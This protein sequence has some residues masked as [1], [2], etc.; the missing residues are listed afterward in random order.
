[1]RRANRWETVTV[2]RKPRKPPPAK[3]GGLARLLQRVR[4]AIRPR[5]DEAPHVKFY[6]RGKVENG[7]AV[8]NS[9]PV[10][11]GAVGW[12]WVGDQ[13]FTIANRVGHIGQGEDSLPINSRRY[14]VSEYER[15][16]HDL[17][18]QA[19]RLEKRAERLAGQADSGS[20]RHELQQRKLIALKAEIAEAIRDLQEKP[21]VRSVVDGADEGGSDPED[22][23]EA[24]LTITQGLDALF[25]RLGPPPDHLLSE[26]RVPVTTGGGGAAQ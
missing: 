16:L 9:K 15:A 19:E 4:A 22:V 18:E 5:H 13:I 2:P 17:H 21:P 14:R 20:D 24:T 7:Q 6:R 1:M 10:T 23:S 11:R 8:D 25:R 12:F 26:Q 3:A